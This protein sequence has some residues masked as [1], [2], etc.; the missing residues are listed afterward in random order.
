MR[1]KVYDTAVAALDGFL[2]DGMTIAAGGFGL[3]GIPELLIAAIRD[4]GTKDLTVASNNAG[5][6]DFGLGVLLQTRQVKKMISSYVG[7]NAGGAMDLVAGVDCEPALKRGSKI[8]LDALLPF[9]GLICLLTRVIDGAAAMRMDAYGR[10]VA[11]PGL[12]VERVERTAEWSGFSP[13]RAVV[14]RPVPPAAWY[15][16]WFAV[17]MD[18]N[19]PT[20]LRTG[21]TS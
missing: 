18:G 5:V 19:W 11:P 3:C 17:G 15:R 10:E 7:E 2:F 12:V 1:R 8:N 21:V 20:C 14:A 4:A 16:G 13:A 9:S 6:D